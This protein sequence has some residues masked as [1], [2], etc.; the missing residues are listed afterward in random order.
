MASVVAFLCTD[1][2]AFVNG[3]VI[4]VDGGEQTFAC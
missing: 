2:A 3:Q 4:R 1:A